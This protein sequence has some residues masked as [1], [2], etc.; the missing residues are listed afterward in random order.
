M[1]RKGDNERGRSGKWENVMGVKSFL[2]S[3][4]QR[5]GG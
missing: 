4:P 1:G 3:C 5:N 2:D